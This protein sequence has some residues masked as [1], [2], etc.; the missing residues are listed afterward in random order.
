MRPFGRVKGPERG[1]NDASGR[2]TNGQKHVIAPPLGPKTR[3]VPIRT[4]FT[5][6]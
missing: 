6:R 3:H 2:G 5:L 4:P 1:R